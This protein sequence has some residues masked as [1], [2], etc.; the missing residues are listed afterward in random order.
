[1]TTELEAAQQA[2]GRLTI[3]V[4][5]VREEADL[6]DSTIRECAELLRDDIVED[7]VAIDALV[8]DA[9]KRV[10]EERDRLRGTVRD[11]GVV[12]RMA[13]CPS[14][15]AERTNGERHEENCPIVAG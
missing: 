10:V 8:L 3:Q 5:R 14:C 6:S 2:I 7:D 12:E 11:T 15:L 13:Q 4:Q 1:M 9:I